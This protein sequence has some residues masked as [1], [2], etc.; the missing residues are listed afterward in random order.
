MRPCHFPMFRFYV[1]NS[2]VSIVEHLNI[3]RKL[4]LLFFFFSNLCDWLTG[5][6]DGD[7]CNL[8]FVVSGL[9]LIGWAWGSMTLF[10]QTIK[11]HNT[12]LNILGV[13]FNFVFLYWC[14]C[15]LWLDCKKINVWDDSKCTKMY[16][17]CDDFKM[18]TDGF[19]GK[20]KQWQ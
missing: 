10:V 6:V 17:E 4:P 7:I 14:S 3:N 11:T 12:N 5:E 2:L 13:L 9:N 15:Q 20:R 16:C 18:P 1:L 19:N 8:K